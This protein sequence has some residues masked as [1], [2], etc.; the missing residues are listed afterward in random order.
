M[1]PA[2]RLQLWLRCAALTALGAAPALASAQRLPMPTGDENFSAEALSRGTF[3]SASEC[4]S[5]SWAVW[6][7]TDSGEAECIRYWAS[8]LAAGQANP[9][10]LIY[11]P[12]D[13]LAFDQPAPGYTSLSPGKMQSLVDEM[14][15]KLGVP[16]LLVARPG[17]FGSSGEHKQRRRVLEPQLVSKALDELKARHGIQELTLVGLSG[18][19]H[20]VASLLGW[21]SDITCAVPTSSVSSPRLR[22]EEMGR[23]TDLTGY[24][25]SYEP[26]PHLRREVFNPR[27][28]VFVLGDPRDSNVKWSTQLPLAA[29]LKE[30]GANVEVVTGE[31]SDA[32]RHALG[33]SGRQIGALC[34]LDTP[35]AAILKAAS[36]GLK[37]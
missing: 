28:R 32:Q 5:L 19:G 15:S 2:S 6:V 36:R 27:L 34:L 18:G 21:R 9:R 8:G 13:Q 37:G 16:V 23:T 24:A 14:A 25:D 30:L 20:T 26:L 7:R 29:R 4:A 10:A 12:S 35:G 11:I 33:A 31:G 22:W 1:K 17:T 3:A